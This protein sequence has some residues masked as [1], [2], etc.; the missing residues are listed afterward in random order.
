MFSFWTNELLAAAIVS[1]YLWDCMK[2]VSLESRLIESTFGRPRPL[3]TAFKLG[4]GLFT[5]INPFTPFALLYKGAFHSSVNQEEDK[6]E[7]TLDALAL[8]QPLVSLQFFWVIVAAP[9][10]LITS[11]D[12]WFILAV[13]A[14]IVTH[15]TM[16][17]WLFY[18]ASALGVSK[19]RLSAIIAEATICLPYSVNILRAVSLEAGE[20]LNIVSVFRNLSV[21]DQRSLASSMAD[22]LQDLPQDGTVTYRLALQSTLLHVETLLNER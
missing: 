10:S 22:Y 11:R 19:R 14:A 20:T 9:I 21:N 17:S 8:I 18:H 4:N 16:A 12:L 13:L 1:L 3:L 15:A 2:R 6:H 5:F 7:A